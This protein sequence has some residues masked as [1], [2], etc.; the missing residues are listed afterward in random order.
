MKLKVDVMIFPGYL[1]DKEHSWDWEQPWGNFLI[2]TPLIYE[3][4]ES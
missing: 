3:L 2:L 1:C 4:R